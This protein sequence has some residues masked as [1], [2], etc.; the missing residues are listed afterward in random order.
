MNK[1]LVFAIAAVL[2]AS[3][4]TQKQAYYQKAKVQVLSERCDQAFPHHCR[5][6]IR[7]ESAAEFEVDTTELEYR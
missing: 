5:S 6:K 3:C 4:Q 2:L 1:F 7:R